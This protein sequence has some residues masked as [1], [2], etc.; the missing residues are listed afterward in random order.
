MISQ[1]RT[2]WASFRDDPATNRLL[3]LG[4]LIVAGLLSFIVFARV[5]VHALSPHF[6]GEFRNHS[7]L[8]SSLESRGATP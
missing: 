4:T 1:W 7:L 2:Y 3:D 5:P 8:L 6:Q